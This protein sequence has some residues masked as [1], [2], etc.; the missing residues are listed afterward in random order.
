MHFNI[1]VI[2]EQIDKLG[3]RFVVYHV[4]LDGLLYCKMKYSDMH[5]WDEELRGVFGDC[6]PPFPPKYYLSMTET[7]EDERRLLLEQYLQKVSANASISKHEIYTL[8]RKMQQET[9]K[10]PIQNCLLEVLL[11]DGD[12]VRT[13][14]LSSDPAERVLEIVFCKLQ[15]PRQ[16]LGYFNLFL[17]EG[18]SGGQYSVLKKLAPFELPYVTL[19]SMNDEQCMIMIRKSYFDPE[20]DQ[21]VMENSCGLNLLYLQAISDMELG[22][23]APTNEQLEKLR[24]L[25]ETGQKKEFLEVAQQVKHYGF[26]QAEACICE[27]P[28]QNSPTVVRV[29]YEEI[30]CCTQLLSNQAEETS[31]E[32][33]KV[34]CWS[35]RLLG[36]S[37]GN[38]SEE[39]DIKLEFS[40]EYCYGN[41]T[42]KWITIHTHQA[43]LLSTFMHQ[44]E[45]EHAAKNHDLIDEMQI[46]MPDAQ[47]KKQSFRK[48][49]KTDK[50]R[51]TLTRIKS[52][53]RG[54]KE[55][56][57]FEDIQ[58]KDL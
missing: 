26:M 42:W 2:E 18:V 41:D 39:D 57:V 14:I 55:D 40:F 23:W 32:I 21:I 28:E 46:E 5:T 25:Q 24:S 44:I 12:K 36:T 45:A 34:R 37:T 58:D 1:P 30:N 53:V 54:S 15:L 49:L 43:F 51:P 56:N 48:Y 11:P 47:I 20:I 13:D 7:M 8:L 19:K 22:C 6:L 52:A 33:S 17:V 27:H 4:Y 35:V 31:F 3:G 9:F 10:I 29:G 16:M 50:A 38:P